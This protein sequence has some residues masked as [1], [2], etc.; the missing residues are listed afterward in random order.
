MTAGGASALTAARDRARALP[1]WAWLA[2]IVVCSSVVRILL[3]RQIVAPWIMVDELIYS[4]L[5]KSFAAHGSFL[6]RGVPSTGYGFVYPIL[7]APAWRLFAAVP[8]AYAAAKDID[9][10]VMSLAALP[11][12]GL[13]RRV[14]PKWHS[15]VVAVL[16][17][18]IPSLLYTGELMTENVFYPVFLVVCLVLVATLER[19][20]AR[21]QVA[22]L[23]LCGFAY[24]TRAQAIALV[25]A[26]L[27]APVLHG[28]VERDLR[29]RLRRY[30]PLYGIVAAAAVIALLA[31][32]ARGRSPLSLLGA[33][34][35]ATGSGYS[36][37]E[38][39][40]YLLW[41][42][43]ELDLYVG[44][45]PFAALL[46]LWLA[47]RAASPAARAFAAA[48]L[49]VAVF[50]LVEVAAF[51]STQAHRIEERNMFYL[52]PFALVALLGL[53]VEGAIPRTRRAL[54]AAALVAGVLPVAI[55]YARF[56]N[57]SAV[58][59]TFA[60]LPWWW[61]QDRG[62][63]FADIRWVALAVGLAAAALFYG[64]PRR[65]TLI[66]PVLVGVYF[67]LTT[68]VVQ[69]GR[70]GIRQTSV[71]VLWAGTRVPHPDWIDRAAGRHAD[72]SFL[73]TPNPEPHP[74]Y[75]NEFFSRSVHTIYAL[76]A[77]PYMG[78]LPE[79]TVHV[80]ADGVV[81]SGARPI[82]PVQYA[83]AATDVAGRKIA[84][85]PKLGLSLF[86]VDGP[87]VVLTRVAGVDGDSW[88]HR[89]VTYRRFQCTG[90]RV[91]VELMTDASLFAGDQTITASE[92][93]QVVE[94]V[95]IGPTQKR[96]L[97]VPLLPSGGKCLVTFVAATTRVPSVVNPQLVPPDHRHL[98]AH[99]LSF[100]YLP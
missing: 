10:V 74:V 99:Y 32:A 50:L 54:A 39:L 18:A 29:P 9:S 61:L 85:D 43:A 77:D 83:V 58:S 27:V 100:S 47:P 1:V 51:A 24:I 94:R 33:Y 14:L 42:V 48:T 53:A 75:N 41:H 88:G 79:T 36:A 86:R 92:N 90:G 65:W 95:R 20:T 31:T 56:V 13:A 16:A 40:R 3:A 97:T 6:V 67:G 69:N 5:A 93:G 64:L 28:L 60:L 78:G 35:A 19:P 11:A 59:D 23:A 22:L 82:P 84:S 73:W 49:P 38:V 98:A 21:R 91:A 55:P 71:G 52:A 63:D 87:L 44:V 70:H 26:V 4:E 89:Y 62:I 17:V 80:R 96:T 30:V 12:Y 34:R 8:T 66:L 68:A 45:I 57:T 76:G 25:P 72:V 46:A 2:A 81:S 37:G 15:L 7:I